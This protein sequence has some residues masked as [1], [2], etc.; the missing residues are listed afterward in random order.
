MKNEKYCHYLIDGEKI[1]LDINKSGQKPSKEILDIIIP[2]LVTAKKVQLIT[3]V[4]DLEGGHNKINQ[5][6]LWPEMAKY[7]DIK[8]CE[9]INFLRDLA[10]GHVVSNEAY[11]NMMVYLAIGKLSLLAEKYVKIKTLLK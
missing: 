10:S 5:D 2:K 11:K 3:N 1:E 8:N 7:L 6:F 9:D 4:N